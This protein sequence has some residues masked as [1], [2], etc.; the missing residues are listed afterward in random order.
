MAYLRLGSRKRLGPSALVNATALLLAGITVG[1]FISMA[2]HR[3]IF[4]AG[5]IPVRPDPGVLSIPSRGYLGDTLFRQGLSHLVFHHLPVK[6]HLAALL[7]PNDG[8]KP[9]VGVVGVEFGME[10]YMFAKAGYTVH[11]FEP[12]P[13]YYGLMATS[14]RKNA[15]LAEQGKERKWDVRVHNIAAGSEN[16]SMKLRYLTEGSNETSEVR[17]RR[18]DD[19]V[20]QELAVLSVD[21]QGSEIDALRGATKLIEESGVR[22]LWIEIFPCNKRVLEVFKLLDEK[23]VMF[24]FVPWGRP[25]TGK[26]VKSD[27]TMNLDKH[28]SFFTADGAERPSEFYA[29]WKWMCGKKKGPYVWIQSDILAIRRD[30]VTPELMVKLATLSHDVLQS[31]LPSDTAKMS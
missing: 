31:S 1:W 2:A 18:I 20:K 9:A 5:M 14:L 4:G 28:P 11:A 10:V 19:Y 30:L 24:D 13:R 6:R 17:I 26:G 12:M 16:G 21:I 23:Y 27:S 7:A 8:S 29:F 15:V 22:S 25:R 3:G